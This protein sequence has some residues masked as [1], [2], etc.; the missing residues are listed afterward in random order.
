LFSVAYQ[1]GTKAILKKDRQHNDFTSQMKESIKKVAMVKWVY[2]RKLHLLQIWK[3]LTKKDLKT[4]RGECWY[5][6]TYAL[7]TRIYAIVSVSFEG[8]SSP[9]RD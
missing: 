2:V 4:A 9:Q 6:R 5:L 7:A 1:R 3:S 8:L